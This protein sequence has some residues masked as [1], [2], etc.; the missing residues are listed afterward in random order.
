MVIIF[1]LLFFFILFISA[2]SF[3]KLNA[4]E[5]K[6]DTR[7]FTDETE[8]TVELIQEAIEITPHLKTFSKP[9]FFLPLK[10]TPESPD[11]VGNVPR[12][13]RKITQSNDQRIVISKTALKPMKYKGLSSKRVRIGWDNKNKIISALIDSSLYIATSAKVI[14]KLWFDEKEVMYS[15]N[16]SI[17]IQDSFIE[18]GIYPAFSGLESSFI[19]DTDKKGLMGILLEEGVYN[20]YILTE[21]KVIGNINLTLKNGKIIVLKEGTYESL[22]GNDK[23]YIIDNNFVVALLIRKGEEFKLRPIN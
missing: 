3:F 10:I 23:A 2:L 20:I 11:S 9:S 17:K 18:D 21:A 1:R 4:Q 7:T 16:S 5:K 19:L 13:E 8:T 15:N 22:N 6:V 14:G 12:K